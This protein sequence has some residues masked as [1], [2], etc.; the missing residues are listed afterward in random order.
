MEYDGAYYM[1]GEGHKASISEKQND[2]DHYVLTFEAI[3]TM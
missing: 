3:D 2:D 1:F